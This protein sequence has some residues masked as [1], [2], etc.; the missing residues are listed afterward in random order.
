M[1]KYL[2]ALFKKKGDRELYLAEQEAASYPWAV[3][4][5]AGF[6]DDGR[7]KVQFAWNSSFIKKIRELGFHAE[8]EDDSVQL[9]FYASQMTPGSDC[10]VQVQ[11]EQHPQ[12]SDPKNL[13]KV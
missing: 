4:E 1:V 10:E 6:E 13:L 9:F 12:L 2:K 8:T 7:V 5:I 3:F 11:S